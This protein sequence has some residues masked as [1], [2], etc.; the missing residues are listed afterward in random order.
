MLCRRTSP[1][2]QALTA[3]L[4][5]LAVWLSASSGMAQAARPTPRVQRQLAQNAA[6]VALARV[7]LTVMSASNGQGG[8]DPRLQAFP[9][10]TRPPFSAF[11]K[12]EFVSQL[13]R[14]LTGTTA[15]F[16][17]P[18]EGTVTVSQGPNTRGRRLTLVVTIQLGG[19]SHQTQFS[20]APGDPF[21]LAHSLGADN[22]L[23]LR[24]VA[25]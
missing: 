8:V 14:P 12:I 15:R 6:P 11:S 16:P 9:Q 19:R 24:F 5:G 23:V 3:K 10:L 25:Q 7:E 1:P 2:I 4:L 20:V 22:A 13:A 21:F 17:I 18:N